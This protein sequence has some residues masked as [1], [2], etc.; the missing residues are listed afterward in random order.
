MSRRRRRRWAHSIG[1]ADQRRRHPVGLTWEPNRGPTGRR[2]RVFTPSHQPL[3]SAWHR[4]RQAV[5]RRREAVPPLRFK[6]S[7]RQ[8][9]SSAWD[10]TRQ[11]VRRRREAV[12]PLRFK[13]RTRPAK[14]T[15]RR[16]PRQPRIRP[17]KSV[18]E[19]VLPTG[20]PAPART[21]IRLRVMGLVM[22]VLFSLMFVRL[23][24]LQVLDTS[25]YAKTVSANAVRPVEVPAARGL[26][27]DRSGSIMVGNQVTEEIV[28]SRVSA[29]QHPSVVSDLSAALG[30]STGQI[31]SD[32]TNPQFSLYSPVPILENAPIADVLYLGEHA[33]QFPGV[34]VE[35]VTTRT[36][37]MCPTNPP[38]QC[39]TG[40]QPFGYVGQISASELAADKNQGYQLGD[41]YGQTGLENEYQTALR[42]TPGTDDVEVDAAG[43]VV[44]SAGQTA[45]VAGDD[46]VTNI[47]AGLEQTLQ[48]DLDA[49]MSQ[50]HGVTGAAV[51]MD[52]E[53]GAVLA[54]V[55]SPTYNPTW[56]NGGISYA[57]YQQLDVN[58]GP[59][60]DYAIDGL[61][62]PGS[63]FKLATATA[64]LND[65]LITPN[66]SYYD[67]GTYDLGGAVFHDN[68]GEGGYTLNVSRALTVSSDD[69]F[70]NLGVL[71]WDQRAKYGEDAIQN[72]ANALGWGDVTGIDLPGETPDARVDSPQVVAKEHAQDPAA[73]PDG[74]WYSGNNL[75]LAFGQG[76]TVITPIEEAQA[77]STFA[78]GGTRYQ[79][80]IAA[81][82][83]NPST[84]KAVETFAPKV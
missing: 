25:S 49:Q 43:Q 71:F 50:V 55:S 35:A 2:R 61:Y 81:G 66:F 12:P 13:R 20:E 29:Q 56:W 28:L 27:L 9:V 69:F 36:Y 38:G 10:R 75:E 63:T 1:P 41:Q 48:A 33:S 19:R 44:G 6:D 73:Y 16:P 59:L 80:E 37:P 15:Q 64:A 23:W 47:D 21:V 14:A 8:S 58:N 40:A 76:G 22:A 3:S 51:A 54:L 32:L 5:R 77:Y 78:N 62:T 74:D 31:D 4:L 84:C 79:P 26:I 57:H 7:S 70:Y 11:A 18:V 83:V 67:S 46:L 34:S 72:A 30:I 65:G 24:Y 52:P 68:E 42:G 45:P 53:T 82:L 39:Q 60:E 17:R